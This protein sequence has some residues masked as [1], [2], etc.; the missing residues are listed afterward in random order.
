MPRRLPQGV[1]SPLRAPLA[2]PHCTPAGCSRRA[3]GLQPA[4]AP[5]RHHAAVAPAQVCRMEGSGSCT[6]LACIAP[7]PGFLQWETR[8]GSVA[9]CTAWGPTTQYS[10]APACCAVHRPAPTTICLAVACHFVHRLQP[11]AYAA[12]CQELRTQ[13]GAH[14]PVL[15]VS[16]QQAF[17]FSDGSDAAGEACAGV[18]I[19]QQCSS[20]FRSYRGV[21][22]AF[23]NT[24]VWC[25]KPLPLHVFFCFRHIFHVVIPSTHPS[26]LQAQPQ[27]PC[28]ASCTQTNPSGR[29]LPPAARPPASG[30]TCLQTW[31]QWQC[32]C[33]S[34]CT[35][36]CGRHMS[37]GP[38]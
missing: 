28:G 18:G 38:S 31:Q 9:T 10:C 16:P 6:A 14:S 8:V 24:V 17:A 5:T 37:A 32:G 29:Q 3:A 12:D 4:H 33:L 2:A 27:P 35:S 11:D 7:T 30:A 23:H 34:L 15:H 19:R 13:S 25:P 1:P 20:I 36:C 21:P 22:C 26:Q